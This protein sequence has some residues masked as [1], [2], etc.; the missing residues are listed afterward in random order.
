MHDYLDSLSSS[1]NF[2]LL[3]LYKGPVFTGPELRVVCVGV[4][5]YN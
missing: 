4:V 2:T 3:L 1:F 5:Y